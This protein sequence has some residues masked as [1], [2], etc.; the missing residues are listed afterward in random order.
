MNK[1]KII[2][3]ENAVFTIKLRDEAG[4][5]FDLTPYDKFKVCLPT[6]SGAVTISEIANAN[7]SIVTVDGI[8]ELGKLKVQVKAA[9]S[10]QLTVDERMNIDLELD[11][12]G[13][14]DPRKARFEN[15]LTVLTSLC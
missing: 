4:D 9:D 10:L 13:T 5:P 7:G 2:Q 6:P 8:S 12:A 15:V 11:N 14:P 1:V 3:G